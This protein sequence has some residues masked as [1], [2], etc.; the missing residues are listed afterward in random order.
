MP[1]AFKIMQRHIDN[2]IPK[3]REKRYANVRN[4]LHWHKDKSLFHARQIFFNRMDNSLENI[5]FQGC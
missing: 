1:N 5:G 3:R 2:G 4:V